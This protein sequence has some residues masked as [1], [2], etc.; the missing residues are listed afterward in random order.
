MWFFAKKH[1]H[2]AVLIDITASSVGGAYVHHVEGEVPTLHYIVRESIAAR[3]GEDHAQAML[4]TLD[5]VGTSLIEIGAPVLRR[6]TGSGHVDSVLV[7]LGAPW[8]QVTVRE[9]SIR[10]GKPFTFSK[11]ILSEVLASGPV[12]QED[13][14][15]GGETVIATLLNGYAIPNPI[16]KTAKYAVVSV[17]SSTLDRVVAE[18]VRA[19]VRKL[20]HAHTISVTAFAA[21]A[22]AAMHRVYPHEKDFL[23]LA[24]GGEGT[25]VA[26]VKEGRLVNVGSVDRG[27]R[28]LEIATLSPERIPVDA[29]LRTTPPPGYVRPGP[30]NTR[31]TW[32]VSLIELLKGFAANHALPRTLFLITDPTS[33]DYVRKALDASILHAL[34]LSDESLKVLPILPEHLHAHVRNR[35]VEESDLYLSLLAIY[36]SS[37]GRA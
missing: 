8:Q 22:Y 18:A 11:R 24:V 27:T 29:S 14:I 17:L 9:Q 2:S 25:D 6:E 19:R 20:Y 16:G 28:S 31:T 21:A 1:A 5:T 10:P 26:C 33:R 36:N 12:P 23:M 7:S 15:S 3:A 4:R 35:S 13:R 32:L 37:I 30:E 34:W